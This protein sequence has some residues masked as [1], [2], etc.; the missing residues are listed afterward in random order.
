MITQSDIAT[1]NKRT[2]LTAK[3]LHRE[4]YL[5]KNVI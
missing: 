2:E 4:K 3:C 1:L 5:L